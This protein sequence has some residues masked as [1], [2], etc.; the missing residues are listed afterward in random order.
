MVITSYDYVFCFKIS[1]PIYS[2]IRELRESRATGG[3][4]VGMVNVTEK[5]LEKVCFLL[6]RAFSKSRNGF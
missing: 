6:R 5:I 4:G 2:E 3:D 1:D